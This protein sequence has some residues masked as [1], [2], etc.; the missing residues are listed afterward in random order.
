M[1][2]LLAALEKNNQLSIGS[3]RKLYRTLSV[4]CHPDVSKGSG[5]EFVRL[6]AEYEE[7]L[8]FLLTN[9]VPMDKEDRKHIDTRARFLRM[10]YIYS[11]M[12]TEKKWQRLVPTLIKHAFDYRNDVGMLFTDYKEAFSNLNVDFRHRN[13]IMQTHDVLLLSIKQL[14]WF[15]ENG[16]AH[17]KRLLSSYLNELAER[18]CNLDKKTANVFHGICGLLRMEAKGQPV[19]LVTIG[20]VEMDGARTKG[21]SRTD[22]K[23]MHGPIDI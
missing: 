15:F 22:N 8:K 17:D 11:I 21:K 16:L 14:A 9:Q 7:A 20:T 19:S 5:K 12:Y 18:S 6:Q 1:N 4:K 13:R 10:L 2:R 3:L 23:D